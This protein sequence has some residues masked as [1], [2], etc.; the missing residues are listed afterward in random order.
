MNCLAF[1]AHG[2][3]RLLNAL[4]P[5]PGN[6]YLPYFVLNRRV[7]GL[8]LNL[9]QFSLPLSR[10]GGRSSISQ[11][12]NIVTLST[13]VP[14]VTSIFNS[15]TPGETY[16]L[17][18]PADLY[19]GQGTVFLVLRASS[20]FTVFLGSCV[21]VCRSPLQNRFLSWHEGLFLEGYETKKQNGSIDRQILEK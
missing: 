15:K 10:S 5:L 8:C 2:A 3:P 9:A 7:C 12:L 21:T 18:F 14:I 1:P 6:S 17:L 13:C 20:P 19:V 4:Y 16:S 11:L